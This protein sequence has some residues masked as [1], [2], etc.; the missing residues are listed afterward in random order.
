VRQNTQ[1][2]ANGPSAVGALE[3]ITNDAWTE[4]Q[5]A[6]LGATEAAAP[7]QTDLSR[8]WATL[9][10]WR[11]CC[12]TAL[13]GIRVRTM[14]ALWRALVRVLF[15]LYGFTEPASR[16]PDAAGRVSKPPGAARPSQWGT[17]MAKAAAKVKR[18]K[19]SR[20]PCPK[21]G[22]KLDLSTIPESEW[23]KIGAGSKRETT[24]EQDAEFAKAVREV[25]APLLEA[26]PGNPDSQSWAEWEQERRQGII[27]VPKI[28]LAWWERDTPQ[29]ANS[30][31]QWPAPEGATRQAR[32][33]AKRS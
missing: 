32:N 21:A 16:W 8:P 10:F 14:P 20:K 7:R 24:P 29:P 4:P 13:C 11:G 1:P 9:P 25:W 5:G 18:R 2:S 17:P 31:P 19:R 26:P 23:R 15:A 30:V 33:I 3:R 12:V 27:R 6:F 22:R 28:P